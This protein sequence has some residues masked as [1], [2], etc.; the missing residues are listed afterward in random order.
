MGACQQPADTLEQ[1]VPITCEDNFNEIFMPK[2][3]LDQPCDVV[4][5]VEDGKE[6]KAHRR[7]LSEASPFFEKLLNSDM[8]ESKEGLVRLEMFSDSVTAAILEFIYTGDVKILDED[9]ARDVIVMADYLFLEKLKT[10]AG[11]VLVQKL[12]ISNCISTY[13][14]SETYQCEELL[15]KTK[16]FILANFTAVYAANRE[17]VLNMSNKEVEMWISS[18]EINVDAEEDVF[19][20]ILAWIDHERSARE[21]YFAELFRQVR[22]VYVSQDFLIGDVV[23]NDLVKDS[24][25]CLDLVKGAMNLSDSKNLAD[26]FSVPPR[27]SLETPVMVIDGCQDINCFFP[28]ENSWCMLGEL[29]SKYSMLANA[30]F[31]PCK[32][33]L[34][35]T[36]I[37]SD[38]YRPQSLSQVSFNP[39]SNSWMKLPTLKEDRYLR[40]IFST[41]EDEMYALMSE[42]CTMEHLRNWRIRNGRRTGRRVGFFKLTFSETGEKKFTPQKECGNRKHISFLT[43]YKPESNSWGDVASFDHLDLRDDFCIVAKDNFIYFIGGIE[44]P[45]KECTFLSDVGRYDLS[46]NQWH[47]VADIQAARKRAH[48]AAVNGK[49]FIAGGVY[50]GEWL[51][52]KHQCEVYDETTN[53]WQF[54]RCFNLKTRIVNLLAV[55]EKL[56]AVGGIWIECY[57]PDKDEWERKTKNPFPQTIRTDAFPMRIFK[58]LAGSLPSQ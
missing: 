51:P 32:G 13:Y 46:E 2:D 5:V 55:D 49:V 31:V 3:T 39:Y 21:K 16:N 10:L 37:E 45:S 24:E 1:A 22:L 38:Y 47:D 14:F 4:L 58:G 11:R 42:P 26:S 7:I 17:D 40:L 19:K 23:T 35:S 33:K 53:E 34:Y 18:D 27:K 50:Q 57:N 6:F 30:K 43:K 36:V 52:K 15:S 54:I 28:R 12:N 44:W 41:K 48:G 29:P 20:T 8:K 25:G 9:N 56:Y